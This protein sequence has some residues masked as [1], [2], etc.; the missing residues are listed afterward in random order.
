MNENPLSDRASVIIWVVGTVAVTA[1]A[2]W[3]S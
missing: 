3:L 1:L 2:W